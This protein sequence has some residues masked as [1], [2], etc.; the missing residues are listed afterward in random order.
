LRA[1]LNLV[2]RLPDLLAE[3]GE[4]ADLAI[5]A[6]ID[7]TQHV[8]SDCIENHRERIAAAG[9]IRR[10]NNSPRRSPVS[11]AIRIGVEFSSIRIARPSP[12]ERHRDA[13]IAGHSLRETTGTGSV[14]SGACSSLAEYHHVLRVSISTSVAAVVRKSGG[15]P[16][17][18]LSGRTTIAARSFV[19]F[20]P[21]SRQA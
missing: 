2:V 16:I 17:Y 9:R 11:S 20:D 21:E 3:V 10:A 13:D 19:S 6:R 4:R 15:I 5:D 14:E 8:R 7:G 12:C 1:A 18:R